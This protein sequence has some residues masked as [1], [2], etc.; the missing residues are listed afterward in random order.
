MRK[1]LI[2]L[3]LTAM[4]ALAGACDPPEDGA[5]PTEKNPSENG[6]PAR[7]EGPTPVETVQVAYRETTAEGTARI[8]YEATTTGS[9]VDPENSAEDSSG[10]I[11]VKGAGATD[12][13]GAASSLT[14]GTPGMGDLEMRQ[15]GETVY[16]KLPDEFAA[17]TSGAKPWVR[18]DLDTLYG[19]QYGGAPVQGGASGDPT[20]QL[21]Y[22]RGVSD[23]VERGGEERVRGVPTTHYE[24]IVDLNREVAGQDAG[25][26]EANQEL[27]KKLGTSKL[28]VEVWVDE[29]NRVRRYALDVSA[30]MPKSAASQGVSQGDDRLRTRMVIEYYD[31]GTPVDVQAPP[32]DQTMDGS[33]LLAG[34]QPA[35][36]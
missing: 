16:V 22:L 7:A 21:E 6:T 26:K 28:P 14:I 20:R 29:E 32:R 2:V 31:F 17:R 8:S 9:T 19:Q 12:F 35:A 23:S 11:T 27:V 10:V 5:S 30:P 13:S 18:V 3:A 15:V 24:A 33:K 4:A 1:L 34:E 36:R 25:V